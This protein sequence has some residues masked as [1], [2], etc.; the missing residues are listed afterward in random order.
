MKR[1]TGRRG[2]DLAASYL[3]RL[4]FEIVDRNYRC[5]WGEIDIICRR[6]ALV[7]FVE[8]RSKSTDR[9]GTPEES[10][11][12]TKVSRIRKTAMEYLREKL[13]GQPIKMRFDLIAITFKERQGNIN[14]I[15]GAF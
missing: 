8:V 10:I 5:K 1:E 14:H 11:N 12:R 9:F 3:S 2:E 13:E 15:E 7:V 6:G 4:G